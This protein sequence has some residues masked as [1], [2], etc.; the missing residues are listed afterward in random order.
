MRFFP[1]FGRAALAFAL[2][3]SISGCGQ[4]GP[5][6]LRDKPPAGVKP[7]RPVPPKPVPYPPDEPRDGQ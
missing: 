7:E 6:Y 4:K 3:L 1:H 5:L 2:T